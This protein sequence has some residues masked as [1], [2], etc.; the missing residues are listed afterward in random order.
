MEQFFM[1]ERPLS[2]SDTKGIEKGSATFRKK[3]GTNDL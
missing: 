2:R 3:G 1:T